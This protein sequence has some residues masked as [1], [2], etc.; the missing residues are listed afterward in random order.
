MS[1][2]TSPRL[3]ENAI[4]AIQAI[5]DQIPTTMGAQA[6]FEKLLD[7]LALGPRRYIVLLDGELLGFTNDEDFADRVEEEAD[8]AIIYDLD[9][10]AEA[11]QEIR[12]DDLGMKEVEDDSDD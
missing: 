4:D 3:S 10:C 9:T 1:W 12:P 8:E 5:V 11:K 6:G 2:K 7:D